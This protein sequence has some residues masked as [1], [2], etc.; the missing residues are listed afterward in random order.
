[1]VPLNRLDII[2]LAIDEP[3]LSFQTNGFTSFNGHSYPNIEKWRAPS[4]TF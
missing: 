1:V 2:C 3:F 4:K